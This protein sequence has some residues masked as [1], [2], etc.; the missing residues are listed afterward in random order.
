MAGH[1]RYPRN[2]DLNPPG[3]QAQPASRMAGDFGGMVIGLVT[4]ICGVLAYF[5]APSKA[6]LLFCIAG[7]A[8]GHQYFL[9]PYSGNP[10]GHHLPGPDL[11]GS[12]P[13]HGEC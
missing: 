4:L 6:S 9:M 13:H 10:S 7:L 1:R 8:V 5:K 3:K 11:R 2:P 12:D